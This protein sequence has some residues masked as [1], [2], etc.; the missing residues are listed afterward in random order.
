MI[1]LLE[2]DTSLVALFCTLSQFPLLNIAY[3]V[4]TLNGHVPNDLNVLNVSPDYP[5]HTALVTVL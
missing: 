1:V 5:Q 3:V 4:A 2:A